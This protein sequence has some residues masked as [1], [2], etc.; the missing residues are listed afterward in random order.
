MREGK[1]VLRLGMSRRVKYPTETA[2][3][4][5]L[6]KTLFTSWRSELE[7]NLISEIFDNWITGVETATLR[8]DILEDNQTT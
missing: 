3:S 6:L 2:Y 1:I 5:I 8:M 7:L 4:D